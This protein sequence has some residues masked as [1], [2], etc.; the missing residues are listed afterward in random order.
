VDDSHPGLRQI[1]DSLRRQRVREGDL[2][3]VL[4]FVIAQAEAVAK[5]GAAGIAEEMRSR[6]LELY[7]APIFVPRFVV[8]DLL[9]ESIAQLERAQRLP[10]KPR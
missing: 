4:D 5:L 3:P 1:V 6:A 8:Q 10:V 2:R 7:R 9:E